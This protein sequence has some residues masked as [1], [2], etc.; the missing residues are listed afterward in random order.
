MGA[1]RKGFTIAGLVSIADIW[2]TAYSGPAIWQAW[3][4]TPLCRI[5]ILVL[6]GAASFTLAD[7]WRKTFAISP[8]SCP[9]QQSEALS[10]ADRLP[11]EVMEGADV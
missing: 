11:G 8:V 3:S 10:L 6:A 9:A 2:V 5:V 7:I 4:G 1:R